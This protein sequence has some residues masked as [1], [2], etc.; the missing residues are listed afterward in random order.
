[1]IPSRRKL[2]PSNQKLGIRKLNTIKNIYVMNL[3]IELV[4]V[5]NKQQTSKEER[6]N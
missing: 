1:M 6:G 5:N 3:C 2:I 4:I